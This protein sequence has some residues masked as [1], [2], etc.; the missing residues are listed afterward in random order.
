M[1]TSKRAQAWG[2][3]LMIASII[4][5]TGIISFYLYSLN[6]VDQ[7]EDKLNSLS[8]DG[9]IIGDM[10]LSEGLPK[11]WNEQNVVTIGILTENKINQT[12]L[13]KFYN[14]ITNN[15]QK[16]KVLFNTKY[17]YYMLI[18]E[19]FTIN[20]QI[21]PGLGKQPQNQR[22]LAKITRFVIYKDKLQNLDIYIWQ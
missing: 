20:G 1:I 8:Y 16:T 12:K 21:K 15:Y 7:T 14:M 13:E 22:N 6:A 10:I 17:D 4:F 5:I 19:N 11:N 3:D 9:N 2:I 18:S